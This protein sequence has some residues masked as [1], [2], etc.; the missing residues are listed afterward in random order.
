MGGVTVAAAARRLRVSVEDVHRWAELGLVELA[1]GN[2]SAPALERARLIASAVRRGIDPQRIVEVGAQ[3]GDPLEPFLALR[4]EPRPLGVG[5]RDAA[6]RAGVDAALAERLW[7]ARGMDP[8]DELFDDD[9]GAMVGI[10]RALE[11]GLPEDALVQI[12]RVLGDAL[13][14]LADAEVRLFHF[15]VHEPLRARHKDASTARAAADAATKA[16]RAL[17]EPAILHTHTKSFERAMRD[18]LVLHL[19]S[20]V[21][22]SAAVAELHVAILFVDLSAY[23]LMTEAMGDTAVVEV[24]DRFSDVVRAIALRHEGR[25]VKQ[26]GDEFMLVFPHATSMVEFATACAGSLGS[27]S[28]FPE[29]RM[30]GHAGP[31]LFREA[32]YLGRTVNMAARIAG[33]ATAGDLLVTEDVRQATADLVSWED[34][35]HHELKGFADATPLFRARFTIAESPQ[36]PVCRMRLTDVAAELRVEWSGKAYRFCSDGCRDRFLDA[37]QQYVTA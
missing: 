29:V 21:N 9:V 11:A 10:R 17:V 1:G 4:G 23:T 3:H 27:E 8:D 13:G 19:A 36:D 35:G 18:D 7:I 34:A 14:R 15:Y 12:A 5:L 20:D 32:D 28:H 31:V 16:L 30:G 33:Q 37:P 22:P 6:E 24:L 2:L 25:V 26:I